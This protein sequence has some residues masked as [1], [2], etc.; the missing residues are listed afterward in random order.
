MARKVV[1]M[2]IPTSEPEKLIEFAS[3]VLERHKKL[4][5]KSLLKELDMEDF[6]KKLQQIVAK[7]KEAKELRQKSEAL[8]EEAQKLLGMAKGQTKDSKGTIIYYLTKGRDILKLRLDNIENS[9]IYGYETVVKI[10]SKKKLKKSN[11]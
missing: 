1:R 11:E 7:R 2:D 6:E 10:V 9:S 8:M 4:K 3:R 5:D